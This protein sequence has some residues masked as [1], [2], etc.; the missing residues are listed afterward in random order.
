MR[1]ARKMED[2]GKEYLVEV[3]IQKN[4]TIKLN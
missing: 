1:G 2:R 3:F 4:V